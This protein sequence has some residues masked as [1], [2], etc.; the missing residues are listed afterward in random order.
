ML[1]PK[2][3]SSLSRL[4]ISLVMR[5]SFLALVC[6]PVI[7]CATLSTGV[8]DKPD[9]TLACSTYGKGITYDSTRDTAQTS[10]EVQVHN[11]AFQNIGCDLK[12]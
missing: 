12:G 3:K 5:L 7:G 2:F 10:H 1:T 8:V 4:R 6:L 11:K 9:A